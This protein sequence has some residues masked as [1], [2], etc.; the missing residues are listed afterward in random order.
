M[1]TVEANGTLRTSGMC[2]DVEGGNDVDGTLIDLY[3]CNGTGA[4]VWTARSDGELYNPLS[5]K[6]LD[7]PAG[8]GSG[9]QLEIWDCHD[10]VNQ[11]WTLP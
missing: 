10:G 6:C 9:T 2:L 11:V 1:W 8:D 5:A 7:D 3:T 4:Q